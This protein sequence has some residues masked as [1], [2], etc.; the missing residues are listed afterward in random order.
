MN[1]AQHTRLSAEL[2]LMVEQ[3]LHQAEPC[4]DSLAR[5]M[6]VAMAT[7]ATSI[8]ADPLEEAVDKQDDIEPDLRILAMSNKIA[9][10]LPESAGVLLKH[11]S[12]RHMDLWGIRHQLYSSYENLVIARPISPLLVDSV[13][14]FLTQEIESPQRRICNKHKD[15]RPLLI[16][17]HESLIKAGMDNG[18]AD[19]QRFL[20][21]SVKSLSQ[22]DDVAEELTS[23]IYRVTKSSKSDAQV[24]AT[25]D[26]ITK[27]IC[28]YLRFLTR[29]ASQVPVFGA[30]LEDMLDSMVKLKE[31]HENLLKTTCRSL[32]GDVVDPRAI[33]RIILNA[34]SLNASKLTA[35]MVLP[36]QFTTYAF[37]WS[38]TPGF[39]NHPVVANLGGLMP[40]LSEIEPNTELL[41]NAKTNLLACLAN[42]CGHPSRPNNGAINR[43]LFAVILDTVFDERGL[44][45]ALERVNDE[46]MQVLTEYVMDSHRALGRLLPRSTKGEYL[47]DA[48]GL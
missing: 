29:C 43:Q 31:A 13:L 42:W 19:M 22:V 6:T 28:P 46:G 23:A 26:I 7:A 34:M 16:Q 33:S 2:M 24:E 37:G 27:I 21:L 18:N 39:A 44:S 5:Q 35:E 11:L 1:N 40:W 9:D 12:H 14:A 3:A 15:L 41:S 20:G 30:S 47:S 4:D 45:V 38:A 25:Q 36:Q 8:D 17:T 48:L 32:C 10:Q